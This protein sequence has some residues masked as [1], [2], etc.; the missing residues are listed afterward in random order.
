MSQVI[1]TFKTDFYSHPLAFIFAFY[2]LIQAFIFIINGQFFLCFLYWTAS[3][4]VRRNIELAHKAKK[5]GK[6]VQKILDARPQEEESEVKE[7]MKPE[8]DLSKMKSVRIPGGESE[9]FPMK[10]RIKKR[11]IS[12]LLFYHILI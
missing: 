12:L 2:C 11:K 7:E 6:F 1:H 9:S 3:L 10:M 5:A 8:Y 4:Y